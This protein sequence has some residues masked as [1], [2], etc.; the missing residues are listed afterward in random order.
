MTDHT[1]DQC[2]FEER[3]VQT[4]HFD[5]LDSVDDIFNKKSEDC[6]SDFILPSK[7]CKM[8]SQK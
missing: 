5:G 7:F 8:I 3:Y 4:P 1:S 6:A 2:Q